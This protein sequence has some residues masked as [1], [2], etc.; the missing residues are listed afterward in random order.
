MD[1]LGGDFAA[2]SEKR[3]PPLGLTDRMVLTLPPQ[4]R[5]ELSKIAGM[6]AQT[7][8]FKN[9]PVQWI[10]KEEGVAPDGQKWLNEQTTSRTDGGAAYIAR[11]AYDTLRIM[12]TMP[13]EEYGAVVHEQRRKALLKISVDKHSV[14]KRPVTLTE[15]QVMVMR[16][17]EGCTFSME[18]KEPGVAVFGIIQF[19]LKDV[20]GV[21]DLRST[22]KTK[23]GWMRAYDDEL[24]VVWC[25]PKE[26]L[27]VHS[28]ATVGWRTKLKKNAEVTEAQLVE[29]GEITR[30]AKPM[31]E[32][33]RT[34]RVDSG[35]EAGET[36]KA[37]E[38]PEKQKTGNE[39]IIG[40]ESPAK[41]E[42][43]AKNRKSGEE[44]NCKAKGS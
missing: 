39:R 43:I 20:Q 22:D 7:K 9:R 28:R 33:R 23:P 30:Y 36:A 32:R 44:R 38:T 4:M 26:T 6:I 34:Q 14:T 17:V 35:S 12:Q 31:P 15:G 29:E 2:W 10:Y 8:Q 5:S 18:D 41:P 3:G 40:E 37:Q 13:S 21:F 42:E 1:F 24:K 16:E 11:V 25:G 19:V 27:Q